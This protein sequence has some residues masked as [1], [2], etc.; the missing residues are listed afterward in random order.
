MPALTPIR[1]EEHKSTVV[2]EHMVEQHNEDPKSI[3]K[4]FRVLRKC[5]GKFECL[6]YE[7]LYVSQNYL[8]TT[9]TS[10]AWSNRR[11]SELERTKDRTQAVVV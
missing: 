4:N 3:E 9:L 8:R 7:M 2:G 5:R 1:I 6:R 10:G 11:H